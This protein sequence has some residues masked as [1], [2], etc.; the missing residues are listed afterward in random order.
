MEL[1]MDIAIGIA[2][3]NSAILLGLVYLYA[4]I[5]VKSRAAYSFGLCFFAAMLLI[6]N[7]LTAFAYGTMSPLF[8]SDA[9][10]YLSIIGGTELAGLLG[11][12]RMTF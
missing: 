4:K 1:L 12:L 8:G 9:L 2:G 11:L 10:P 7:L 5:A 6:Q 3:I